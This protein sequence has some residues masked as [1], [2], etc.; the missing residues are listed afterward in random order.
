M[1]VAQRI[2]HRTVQ[3]QRIS[4]RLVVAG[5]ILRMTAEELRLSLQE[6]ADL[7]P[8]LEV[9]WE[10]LCPTCG[11]G[12]SGDVC[13]FCRA[14][15]GDGLPPSRFDEAPLP[16]LRP[17]PSDDEAAY[18]PLESAQAPLSLREFVLLQARVALPADDHQIAEYLVADL[19]DDGLLTGSPED[20]AA[21]LGVDEARV[22]RVLSVLQ[23][24][25]PP[26]VCARSVHESVLIQ[27]RQLAVE[28]GVPQ[29]AEPILTSHWNDLANHSYGK[30]A[31]ALHASDDQVSEAVEFIRQNLCP[32]PGRLYHPPH[33]KPRD[34]RS[35]GLRFD[36]AIRRQRGDYRVDVVR[37]FDFELKVSEAYRRLALASRDGNSASPEHHA[38]LEQYRRAT[39]MLQSLNLR[40]QTLRQ[41][42]EYVVQTQRPFLDTGSEA[43]MKRVTQTQAAAHIGKHPSTVSRAISGKFVLLPNDNLIA[44]E[45]FFTPALAPKNVIAELLSKEDPRRPLTDEQICRIL[46]IRGF[47]IARRTVA[48]Y[49]LA[50]RLPNSNQR[51]RH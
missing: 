31:R 24:L 6:E 5:T 14:A 51:G 23:E 34:T 33:E 1:R 32:Y 46:R 49:R 27:L 21:A 39:W 7:N 16:S 13:W 28:N 2:E 44:F 37:P 40:E 25:E 35:P 47:R 20:A 18:D 26:G 19:N 17:R 48:K 29:L 50:L 3:T 11:R 10:N 4:P 41:I 12:L 45:R 38:A 30:I 42:G 8:A 9:V 43:K 22:L 15:G 36:V